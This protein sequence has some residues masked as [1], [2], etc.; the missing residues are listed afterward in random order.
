MSSGSA[1]RR[2]CRRRPTSRI[3]ANATTTG[4]KMP[5]LRNTTSS[6]RGMR[7][8]PIRRLVTPTAMAAAARS[9]EQRPDEWMADEA[10]TIRPRSIEARQRPVE[11]RGRQCEQHRD[12]VTDRQRHRRQKRIGVV[13]QL[14]R[15]GRDH[16]RAAGRTRS[17]RRPRP[18]TRAGSSAR[19]T[20][21]GRPRRAASCP[22]PGTA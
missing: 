20:A 8:V 3:S 18:S 9:Q 5:L 15:A 1:T 7:M 22:M 16:D 6:R 21:A 11:R 12:E 19:A 14:R 10:G 2:A 13:I 17:A 4:R